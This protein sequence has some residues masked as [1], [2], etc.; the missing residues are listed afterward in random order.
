MTDVSKMTPLERIAHL[1]AV[2]AAKA[3]GAAA[4]TPSVTPSVTN[5]ARPSIA[6]T[7]A[8]TQAVV[9]TQPAQA[10]AQAQPTSLA[11]LLARAKAAS[12]ASASVVQAP[13]PKP[14]YALPTGTELMEA[15]QA[16]LCEGIR[17][18]CTALHEQE[19]GI[20]GWLHK[21]HEQL[22]VAPELAHM[23]TDEQVS[24]LYKSIIKQSNVAIVPAAKAKAKPKAKP[25]VDP[26]GIDDM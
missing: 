6:Q 2:A 7:V 14:D 21:V 11:T 12:Q 23:L 17:S 5:P 1:K 8:A 4:V 20:S 25:A 19:E 18:L 10:Q 15:D 13:P 26:T 16:L 22:R 9:A 24:V 3:S